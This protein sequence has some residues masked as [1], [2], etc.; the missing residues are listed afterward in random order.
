MCFL[1]LIEPCLPT[2]GSSEAIVIA[3]WLNDLQKTQDKITETLCEG[4][5]D[6]NGAETFRYKRFCSSA[7]VQLPGKINS[8]VYN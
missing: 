5:L 3:Q 1:L 4:L 8:A 7:K 2:L 6:V